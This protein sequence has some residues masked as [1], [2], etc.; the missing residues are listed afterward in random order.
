MTVSRIS[1]PTSVLH[2]AIDIK[3]PRLVLL[4]CIDSCFRS[5]RDTR[6]QRDHWAQKCWSSLNRV[7]RLLLLK[8]PIRNSATFQSSTT[9]TTLLTNLGKPTIA[10]TENGHILV[11]IHYGEEQKAQYEKWDERPHPV[12]VRHAIHSR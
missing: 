4:G 7:E 1:G 11:I 5:Q 6:V 9:T 12:L 8:I 10:T 2:C 3:D